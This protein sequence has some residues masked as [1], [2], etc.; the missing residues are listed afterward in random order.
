MC[1]RQ[2][3]GWSEGTKAA[4]QLITAESLRSSSITLHSRREVVM[5]DELEKFYALIDDID[6]AMMTTRRHDGHLRS[7]AMAN[8]KQVDG[9]DLWFVT[10]E[11]TAKLQDLAQDPHLNLGYY[12][13]STREWISVSGIADHLT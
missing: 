2:L 4:Y 11:G 3:P 5:K 7:R 9:A 6:T 8:Q 13:E 10:S 1:R 12:R